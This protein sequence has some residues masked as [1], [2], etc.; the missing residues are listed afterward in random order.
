MAHEAEGESQLSTHHPELDVIVVDGLPHE[1]PILL[2]DVVPVVGELKV[3]VQ[4]CCE[5]HLLIEATAMYP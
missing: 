2:Y 1:L 3:V 4:V 5:E